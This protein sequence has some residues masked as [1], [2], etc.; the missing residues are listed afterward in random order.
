MILKDLEE[1]QGTVPYFIKKKGK[2]PHDWELSGEVV[3]S[4]LC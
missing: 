4:H 2:V 3:A 1:I